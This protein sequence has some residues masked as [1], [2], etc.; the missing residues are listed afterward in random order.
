MYSINV[1][2]FEL[3]I[4]SGLIY[5]LGF[6]ECDILVNMI[7]SNIFHNLLDRTYVEV[8]VMYHVR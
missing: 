5:C 4:H 3:L 1:K 7:K 8:T 2:A 6:F